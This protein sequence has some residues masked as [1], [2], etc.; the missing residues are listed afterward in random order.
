MD[1][2]ADSVAEESLDLVRLAGSH[3]AVV[4]GVDLTEPLADATAK[5]LVGFSAAD[6][7]RLL[8]ILQD[9]ITRPENTVRWRW[10]VGR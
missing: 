9:H 6:S 1:I 4:R 8:A 10:N 3:G 2:L 5:Q 7:Q